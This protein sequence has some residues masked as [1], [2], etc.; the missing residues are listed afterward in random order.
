[1]RGTVQA[2]CL[3]WL[4]RT[5]SGRLV[6]AAPQSA[7]APPLSYAQHGSDWQEGSC[8]SRLH[9][10]PIS[11]DSRLKEAPLG[12]FDYFYEPI[13]DSS[14]TL[15]A[16]SSS[17]TL[18]LAKAVG[19][20]GLPIGGLRHNQALYQLQRIDIRSQ[21]EHLIAGKRFP[22]ELQLVHREVGVHNPG[23]WAIVSVLVWCEHPLSPP[24]GGLPLPPFALPAASDMDFNVNLQT[25]V[26]N[27]PPQAEGGTAALG[28]TPQTPLDLTMLLENRHL[29]PAERKKAVF[30][31][32]SGSLSA[33]PCEETALWFVRRDPIFASDSQVNA[34]AAA[35]F[36]LTANKGNYRDVMPLN[37]RTPSPIAANYA[38]ELSGAIGMAASAA[39]PGAAPPQPPG[40]TLPWGPEPRTD[41]ELAA[42]MN[43]KV[44]SE[45]AA[46]TAAYL[47]NLANSLAASERAYAAHLHTPAA[48][49]APAV[50][51]PMPP[52]PPAFK[53]AV[54]EAVGTLAI[55][56]SPDALAKATG[57]ASA[58]TAKAM[59]KIAAKLRGESARQAKI[60]GQMLR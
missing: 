55:G 46:S 13:T 38:A 1:M 53:P 25:L 16:N 26:T 10:S 18:D 49:P 58:E 37:K 30:M 32:Y 17:M 45:R 31:H 36:A 4:V 8:A 52:P 33:P 15:L 56:G 9:Q 59:Q 23:S 14:L 44:A 60:A 50:A 48:A 51:A 12:F 42:H 34:L 7:A 2:F 57:I 6:Q 21:S 41:K 3:L 40:P 20:S 28:A 5:V 47:K 22:L 54:E 19:A 35:A 39:A 24:E 43:A 11:L 27:P 29:P